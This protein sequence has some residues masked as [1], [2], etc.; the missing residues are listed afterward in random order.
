VEDGV[1]WF[2]AFSVPVTITVPN[3]P[4]VVVSATG[5]NIF[6]GQSFSSSVRATD[7]SGDLAE[8]QLVIANAAFN[9]TANNWE[10]TSPEG[11]KWRHF[12]S[13]SVSGADTTLAMVVQDLIYGTPSPLS[14]GSYR[15]NILA[16]DTFP[17]AT[18]SANTVLATLTVSAATPVG[19][20]PS[21]RNYNASRILTAQDLNATFANPYTG[22]T[23]PGTATYKIQSATGSSASPSAGATVTI[24][25]ILTPGSYV[26]RAT[27]PAGGNYS[28]GASNCTF[29]VSSGP[30]GDDDGDNIPNGVEQLMGSNSFN[31]GTSDSSNSTIQLNVHK[32]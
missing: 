8:Y 2:G 21:P 24:G 32:P 29:T 17:N 11:W 1:Q 18:Y 23:A 19:T 31:P 20:Y 6:Y 5:G 26:I 27:L 9:A 13:S 30:V 7:P 22:V 12:R 4:P 10:G 28:Q 14:I 25:T 3:P 16:R 15:I